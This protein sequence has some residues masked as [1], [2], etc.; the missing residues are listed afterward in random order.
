[1]SSAP[2]TVSGSTAD[3]ASRPAARGL[4]ALRPPVTR[5][6]RLARRLLTVFGRLPLPV[7]HA[8]AGLVGT[9]LYFVPFAYRS[10]AAVNL[11]RCLPELG[12]LARQWLLLR[13][14]QETARG[15]TEMGWFWYRRPEEALGKI[16]EVRG[17][18]HFDEAI[19]A[20]RPILFAG[21]HLGAWELLNGYLASRT[22]CTILYRP[23][24]DQG[25]DQ[26]VT[27]A[28]SSLGASMT[29]ADLTGV[30]QLIRRIR[31]GD[32]IGILPDHK[33]REGNGLFAPFFG[34]PAYTTRLFS[35]LAGRFKPFVIV[36]FAERLA[37]GRGYRIHLR[38]LDPTVT[39]EDEQASVEAL[40][41]DL[42]SM[43]RIAPAQ[44]QW[45]YQRF[46]IQPDGADFG[47]RHRE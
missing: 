40:N 2:R 33:P 34:H 1:M 44:Y 12:W 30:R 23:R 26:L 27:D 47:Y 6:A 11:R 35:K 17:E 28:R 22:Q 29:R 32:L 16:R 45:T 10:N 37:F 9:L 15:M 18:H 42:E 25:V 39:S 7:N 4:P 41:R 31:A 36:G 46:D 19:E 3:D 13:S 20:K 24:S 38:P 43:I 8:I 21:L 14:L 5:K